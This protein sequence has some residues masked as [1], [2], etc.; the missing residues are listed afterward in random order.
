ME[1]D[2]VEVGRRDQLVFGDLQRSRD[3]EVLSMVVTAE[4]K[5]LTAHREVAAH[6]GNGFEDLARFLTGLAEHWRGWIGAKM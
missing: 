6:Y 5:D 3:G 1:T 2:R 4:L